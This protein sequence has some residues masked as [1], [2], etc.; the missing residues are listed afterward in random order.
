MLRAM[1]FRGFASDSNGLPAPWQ[2]RAVD[3][4]RIPELVHHT[5][6]VHLSVRRQHLQIHARRDAGSRPSQ[7]FTA[8]V[9]LLGRLGLGLGASAMARRAVDLVVPAGNTPVLLGKLPSICR[10]MP[11]ILRA[12]SFFG[13]VSLAKSPWTWQ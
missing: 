11:I 13:F 12:T 9:E 10:T 7:R 5:A 2:Y 1:S 8:V 6:A 4:E 3:V